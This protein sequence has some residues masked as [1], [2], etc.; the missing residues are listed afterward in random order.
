MDGVGFRLRNPGPVTSAGH[1]VTSFRSV[2]RAA[3]HAAFSAIVLPSEN[4]SCKCLSPIVN[5]FCTSVAIKMGEVFSTIN[6]A[7][8]L[9]SS[10]LPCCRDRGSRRSNSSHQWWLGTCGHGRSFAS[11]HMPTA[12]R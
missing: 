2:P 12:T 11:R 4:H 7:V 3:L 9:L 5:T 10:Y 6:T 8:V 1:M